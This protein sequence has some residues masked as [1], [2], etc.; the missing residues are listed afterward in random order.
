MRYA[1][2]MEPS[3]A[4]VG[5]RIRQHRRAHGLSV[6]ELAARTGT[7][8]ATISRVE[9]GSIREPR[10]ALLASIAIVFGYRSVDV[11]LQS[12][13]RERPLE[14]VGGPESA[15]ANV[16]GPIEALRPEG[17]QPLPIYRWGTCGDPRDHESPPDPDR[18]EYP[19]PGRELLIGPNGFGVEVRGDSMAN[20]HIQDGDVVWCNPDRPPKVG[21]VVLARLQDPNGGMVVKVYKN[22]PGAALVSDGPGEHAG[23]PLFGD[24]QIIGPI[25]LVSP[26]PHPP[27]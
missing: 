11:M 24:F 15:T 17:A 10:F 12:G 3:D 13:P 14:T 2:G 25:V 18:L 21:G 22:A 4:P 1:G 6:E 5:V 7:S 23:S 8:P 16:S 26:K 9:R 20:R 19:P 27:G